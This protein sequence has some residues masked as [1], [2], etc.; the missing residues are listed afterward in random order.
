MRGTMKLGLQNTVNTVLEMIKNG[1]DFVVDE[2]GTGILIPILY[3]K[4]DIKPHVC[5][6]QKAGVDDKITAY[7]FAYLIAE[8]TC[9]VRSVKTQQVLE[10]QERLKLAD[11]FTM[12]KIENIVMNKVERAKRERI[13]ELERKK[14][15]E[16]SL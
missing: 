15:E 8:S 16:K 6:F 7:Y 10:T 4:H 9:E 12:N 14:E 3:T 11:H 13:Y 5:D 2:L 1:D